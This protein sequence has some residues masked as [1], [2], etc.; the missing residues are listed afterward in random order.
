MTASFCYLHLNKGT[1]WRTPA[2]ALR[3]ISVGASGITLTFFCALDWFL[4]VF[5]A[6]KRLKFAI[7]GAPFRSSR[8]NKLTK[9]NHTESFMHAVMQIP[10]CGIVWI[11][12]EARVTVCANTCTENEIFVEIHG[13]PAILQ[14]EHV[15]VNIIFSKVWTQVSLGFV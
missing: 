2:E 5:S 14:S 1:K 8:V 6:W 10:G 15:T 7:K 4:V 12:A 3:D 9:K 13:H 11:N